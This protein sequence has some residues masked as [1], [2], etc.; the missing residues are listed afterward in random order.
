[1][2]GNSSSKDNLITSTTRRNTLRLAGGAAIGTTL[3]STSTTA[4]TI[5]EG[6]T[7]YIGRDDGLHAVNAETGTDEWV[8]ERDNAFIYSSPTVADGTV[9]VGGQDE[10]L[11]AID[12]TTGEEAWTYTNPS[13]EIRSSPTVVDDTVF[14]GGSPFGEGTIHA[15]DATTGEQEWIFTKPDNGADASPTVVDGSVYI[16]GNSGTVYSI[17]TETGNENWSYTFA[18]AQ[19]DSRPTVAN[20]TV[21]IGTA[22]FRLIAIDAD[23]GE[24]Q[25]SVDEYSGVI[26]APTVVDGIVYAGAGPYN[27]AG[28]LF[29]VN[30]ATGEIEWEFATPDGIRRYGG[31]T[32]FNGVVYVGTAGGELYAVDAETGDH[33]WVFSNPSQG[34][35]S[36]PTVYENTVYFATNTSIYSVDSVTGEQE[37]VLNVGGGSQSS[38]TIVEDPNQGGSVGSRVNLGTLGHTNF[39]AVKSTSDATATMNNVGTSA[40]EI[41]GT[42][43]DIESVPL[44]EDNPQISLEPGTRYM[45]ENDGWPTHP[46]GFQ[47]ADGTTLLSQDTDSTGSFEDNSSINWVDNGDVFAFTLTETLAE[48]VDSYICTVHAP[49]NG[50][51]EIEET[52]A[53]EEI[54]DAV[55]DEE[56]KAVLDGDDSLGASNLADAIN[57]WSNTGT[58]NDVSVDAGALSKM[59]NYWA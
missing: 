14:V 26:S 50:E 23:S 48:E 3:G 2:D 37:W 22:G 27:D 42:E 17:D 19:I 12:A 53:P 41:T 58:V 59:I 11:Y 24:E 47:S 20:G 39:W 5:A 35:E 38:P 1:M 43:G 25:W 32:V 4:Q 15:V 49:M 31:P 10:K 9:Y 46:L 44:N 30:A 28:P 16:S 7:V 33:E 13:H 18:D 52:V 36:G 54:S 57:Q 8:F 55:T 45:I 6:S 56:Y 34:I 40:W 29:A 51:I 21:Y